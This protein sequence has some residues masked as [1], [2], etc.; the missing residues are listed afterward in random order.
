MEERRE[1]LAVEIQ[2]VGNSLKASKRLAIPLTFLTVVVAAECLT[3]VMQTA[4]ADSA[5]ANFEQLLSITRPFLTE[6]RN[7]NIIRSAFSQ[8]RNKSDYE[9]LIMELKTIA[10]KQGQHVPDFSIW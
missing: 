1:E 8:I 3:S 9:K 6:P 7:E 2:Q 4:Y 5:V 10:Q